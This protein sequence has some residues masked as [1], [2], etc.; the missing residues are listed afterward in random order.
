MFDHCTLM[1]AIKIPNG[2]TSIGNYA[3]C[4][5]FSVYVTYPAILEIPDSVTNIGEYALSD[6][7]LLSHL[8]L[9]KGFNVYSEIHNSFTNMRYQ[10]S[11]DITCKA[12]Q[13]PYHADWGVFHGGEGR[14]DK[15]LYILK[16]ATGYENWPSALHCYGDGWTVV[17]I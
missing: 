8:I 11:Y 5:C 12:M 6:L 3:F 13:A 4:E 1:E 17:E 14:W 7:F 10:T 15:T 9:G 16:G 2:I